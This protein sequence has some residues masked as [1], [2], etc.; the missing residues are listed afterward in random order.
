MVK[1]FSAIICEGSAE[2]AIIE[3]LLEKECLIIEIDDYLIN[4]G[5][6]RTR[7]AK[8]FCD[9]YMGKNYA[10]KIDLFRIIDSRNEKFNFGSKKYKKIFEEKINIVNVIT[11]PEIEL[12]IIVNENKYIDFDKSKCNK[13]S[14]YCQQVLKMK[15][16]KSFD[17]VKNYFSNENDLINAIKKVHKMKKTVIPPNFRTLYDLLKPTLKK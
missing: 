6:I 12:L 16:V 8:N 3:I 17:F 2:Q 11:P 4:K 9:T 14:D 5:P 7:S 15:D 1:N 13:P 10:S